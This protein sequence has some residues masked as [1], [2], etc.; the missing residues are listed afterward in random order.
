MPTNPASGP[1]APSG[2]RRE[3][4]RVVQRMKT[5]APEIGSSDARDATPLNSTSGSASSTISA[6]GGGWRPSLGALQPTT[7]SA[8][9]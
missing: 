3:L 2:P 8:A 4:V 6:G 5:L 9:A 7:R 1:D